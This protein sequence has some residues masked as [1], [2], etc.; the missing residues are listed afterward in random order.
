MIMFSSVD[1][2]QFFAIFIV[3]AIPLVVDPLWPSLVGIAANGGFI[4][5]A[6]KSVFGSCYNGGFSLWLLGIV[7][8]ENYAGLDICKGSVSLLL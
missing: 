7:V 2:Y 6:V 1:F 8:M 5:S 3:S 4:G